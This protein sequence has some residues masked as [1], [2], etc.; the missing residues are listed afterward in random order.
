MKEDAIFQQHGTILWELF[1]PQSWAY[2]VRTYQQDRK[3]LYLK[4][5]FQ[6]QNEISVQVSEGVRRR[7]IAS[8]TFLAHISWKEVFG[9]YQTD[10]KYGSEGVFCLFSVFGFVFFSG[11]WINS[12]S[13]K[14]IRLGQIACNREA[15]LAFQ[16]YTESEAKTGLQ[17]HRF[18]L[19]HGSLL[20]QTWFNAFRQKNQ[21]VIPEFGKTRSLFKRK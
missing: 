9:S 3:L 6:T 21:P 13:L 14:S 11:L 10:Q 7:C 19:S 2:S 1:L 12:P 18:C 8:K 16:V 4:T 5:I 17:L 15:V 20:T